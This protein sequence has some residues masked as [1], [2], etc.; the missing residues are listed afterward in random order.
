MNA[1]GLKKELFHCFGVGVEIELSKCN[2]VFS[3][4]SLSNQSVQL[5]GW[6]L[7]QFLP[8]FQEISRTNEAAV[9]MAICKGKVGDSTQGQLA[10]L[11]YRRAFESSRFRDNSPTQTC[12]L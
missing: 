4:R 3:P 6:H 5:V 9:A 12:V 8:Y 1:G 7:P 2:V 11:G 10:F